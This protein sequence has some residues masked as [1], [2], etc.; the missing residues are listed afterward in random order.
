MIKALIIDDEMLAREEL[1]SSLQH[2]KDISVI[3]EASNAI[4]GLKLIHQFKPDAIFLDIHMPQISGIELL[5]MLNQETLPFVIFIT[6]YDQYAIQAFEDNAFD[7]LLKPIQEERLQKT[8]HKL[9]HRTSLVQNI[10]SIVPKV[11]GQIPCLGWNRILIIPI[12]EVELV[13]SDLSGVHVKTDTQSATS[14]LTLKQL[15]EKTELIRCHRQYLLNIKTMN[16]IRLLDNG[17]AEIITRSGNTI[18]V[19]RRYL[20]HI[21]EVIGLSN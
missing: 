8:I 5:T 16:E 14:Q 18:P 21:K 17:L 9:M 3:G 10:Q 13:Y 19:S 12:E 15:E 2:F 6:A 1:I 4:D 20:K 11:L 7:Y